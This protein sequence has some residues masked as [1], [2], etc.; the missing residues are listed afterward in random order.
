MGASV[1]YVK[2]VPEVLGVSVTT[3][4][5][6]NKLREYPCDGPT[7][8]REV[9][10]SWEVNQ[11]SLVVSGRGRSRVGSSASSLGVSLL[12]SQWMLT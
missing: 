6:K 1:G 4:E 2:M 3:R 12:C 8:D 10:V 7:E 5:K 9:R 11:R